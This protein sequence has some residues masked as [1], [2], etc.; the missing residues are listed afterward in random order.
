MEQFERILARSKGQKKQFLILTRHFFYRLFINDLVLFEEAIQHKIV[1][2]VVILSVISGHLSR[3]LLTKY[4]WIPD[5]NTSWEEKCYF[6]LFGM[7]I[8]GF[9]AV[10]EWDI[11]FPDSRDFSN[12]LPLPI[13]PR[14]L[15]LSKFAS[16]F[17]FI[18]LFT[19][20]IT[21]M[22]TFVFWIYLPQWQSPSLFFSLRFVVVHLVSVYAACLSVAFI[23]ALFIG[24]LMSALGHRIFDL[25]SV[26][27]RSMMMIAL[28]FLMSFFIFRI[29]EI[30]RLFPPLSVLKQTGSPLLYFFPPMWFVGLYETML[31]NRDPLFVD[32]AK[33]AVT[34]VIL[35]LLGFFMI[36]AASYRKYVK[37]MRESRKKKKSSSI[38]RAGLIDRFNRIFLKNPVQRA[39]FYFFVNSIK[40]SNLHRMRLASYMVVATGIVL[41]M[42]TSRRAPLE[43]F[44]D[45]DKTMLSIPFVLSFFLVM[46]IRATANIPI[47]MEA[48]WIF[49]LS[50]ITDKKHYLIGFKKAIIFSS[51]L[52][53]FLSLLVFYTILWGWMI[54]GF[55]CLYGFAITSLLVEIVFLNHRKIPFTCSYLPGKG[56]VHI[57]WI[58]YFFALIVF[59]SAV[60]S[61]AYKLLLYP[62]NYFYFYSIMLTL[63]ML[64]RF[65][66]NRSFLEKAGIIY[67]EKPEP[68][69]L[70]LVP[71]Q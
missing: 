41:I 59:V 61:L 37:K 38:K 40:K 9:I 51:I 11:I 62:L 67:E 13:Q 36:S 29:I 4:L 64:I 12:L 50:E 42:L 34:A 5:E 48:N 60:S 32:L 19:L 58:V 31:G 7:L 14:T 22:S 52:P 70:T 69:L 10:L 15:F 28:V 30:P 35:P 25:I 33:L 56:K 71:E 57:H 8:T 63:F 27:I 1:A 39:I 53:L 18:S 26:Y 3:V 24:I 20:G 6:L 49:R 47:V 43:Y 23:L 68:A 55:F 2:L 66:Q 45:F 17:I 21:V 54:A 44:D 16:Y 65:V 46:G